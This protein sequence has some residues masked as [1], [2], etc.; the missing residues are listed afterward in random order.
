MIGCRHSL[1]S[2]K[3]NFW[4]KGVFLIFK[5]IVKMAFKTKINSA[6]AKEKTK[7]PIRT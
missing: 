7:I 4:L 2:V 3:L 5:D 1:D 6:G